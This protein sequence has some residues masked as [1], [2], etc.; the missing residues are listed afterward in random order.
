DPANACGKRVSTLP[1]SYPANSRTPEVIATPLRPGAF[2]NVGA[3]ERSCTDLPPLLLCSG[4]R[5]GRHCHC[6]SSIDRDCLQLTVQLDALSLHG[7][8]GLAALWMRLRCQLDSRWVRGAGQALPPKRT[9]RLAATRSL[10]SGA[11]GMNALRSEDSASP[12]TNRGCPSHTSQEG[13]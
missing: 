6:L 2:V 12:L 9:T 10:R 4:L 13:T 8:C 7:G 1:P 5:R 3:G 11:R